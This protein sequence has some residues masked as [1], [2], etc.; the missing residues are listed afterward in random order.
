MVMSITHN[1]R[2]A[3]VHEARKANLEKRNKRI[4]DKFNEIYASMPKGR[5]ITIDIN[6]IYEELADLFCIDKA[7]VVRVLKT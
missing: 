2:L 3:K 5:H 1:S 6:G 4:A 7:T